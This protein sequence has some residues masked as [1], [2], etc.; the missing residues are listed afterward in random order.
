MEGAMLTWG[1]AESVSSGSE[2]Q[3]AIINEKKTKYLNLL[4]IIN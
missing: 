2:L 4:C 3:E 1:S